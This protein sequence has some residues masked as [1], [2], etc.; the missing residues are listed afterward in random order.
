MGLCLALMP[1]GSAQAASMSA[2]D[3][4]PMGS[5]TVWTYLES[6]ERQTTVSVAQET[7]TLNNKK[8]T[9][10]RHAGGQL[11]DRQ[12]NYSNDGDG[13]LF[14]Y[15]S[16]VD[17]TGQTKTIHFTTP[18]QM[19]RATLVPGEAPLLTEGAATVRVEGGFG[20]V[21]TPDATF[22]ATSTLGTALETITVP[23]GTFETL[24]LE[25][26][27]A[28]QAFGESRT[29]TST[30][31]LARSM[32]VV[33]EISII[34]GTE[35]SAALSGVDFD[36]GSAPANLPPTVNTPLPDQTA[37][38]HQEFLFQMAQDAFKDPNWGNTLTYAATVVQGKATWP[39]W[40]VF[41]TIKLTFQGTPA[42]ADAGHLTLRVTARDQDGLTVM[43]EFVLDVLRVN[44]PPIL[45]QP[46]TDHTIPE[47]V[48]WRHTFPKATFSDPDPDKTL[49]FS[50]ALANDAPWPDWLTFHE[51]YRTFSGQPGAAHGGQS[52]EVRVTAQDGEGLSVSD[53]FV[54][55]VTNRNDPPV[56]QQALADQTAREDEAWSFEIPSGTF[57]DPDPADQQTLS[58]GQ[59]GNASLPTWL[60]FDATTRTLS[61]TPT[62]ADVGTVALT[63]TATD[64]SDRSVVA[65][66]TLTVHGT[67]DAPTVAALLPAQRALPDTSFAFQ[68]PVDTF[69]DENAGDTLS[70]RVTLAEGATWLAF[71]PTTRTLSGT[72]GSGDVGTTQ[73]TVTVTD[74]GGKIATTP[75][76]L[77]ISPSNQPP[78]GTDGTRTLLEDGHHLLA[79]TDFGFSDPDGTDTL[80]QVRLTTLP[81]AGTVTW[82]GTPVTAQQA[83]PVTAMTAGEIRYTPPP[84]A[85]G[86]GYAT[87]GFQVSDGLVFST[88][89]NTLTL[90][91]TPIN[92]APTLAGTPP[93]MAVAGEVFRFQPAVTDA[94]GDTLLF[95]L[96]HAPAW[97]TLPE[98]S[99][100]ILQGTPGITD[101]GTTTG[102]TLAAT[103][104]TAQATLTFDLTVIVATPTG[105]L[106]AQQDQTFQAQPVTVAAEDA[107]AL[108]FHMNHKPAWLTLDAD[109]GALSGT[110]GA[111]H[112]GT[113]PGLFLIASRDGKT[114]ALPPF[115]LTVS[116]LAP[117]SAPPASPGTG[118]RTLSG[119][120][121][122]L[123]PW[124]MAQ[125]TAWSPDTATALSVM[126]SGNEAAV[127]PFELPNL[128][129][130]ADYRLFVQSD[131][132]PDGFWD[133]TTTGVT[134]W[135]T[136]TPLNLVRQDIT[137]IVIALTVPHTLTVA[138]SGVSEGARVAVSAWS[139]SSGGFAWAQA[140]A[141]GDTLTLT[142]SG[143]HPA[144]DYRVWI[145][146]QNGTVRGGFYAGAD[147]QPG[148]LHKAEPVDLLTSDGSISTVLGAGRTLSGSV[149]SLPE[150]GEARIT[151]WSERLALGG[152]TTTRTSGFTLRGLPPAGDYR[153][154][155]EADG[156]AGGCYGGGVSPTSVPYA[157][158]AWVDLRE[159]DGAGIILPLVSGNTVTGTLT[160][161][162]E[163]DVAW[164]TVHATFGADSASTPVQA[165]GSFAFS[166]LR[167]DAE[168]RV[169]VSAPGY[170]TPRPQ[171]ISFAEVEETV[172]HF[173]LLAGGEIRGTL[174]GLA[175][176]EV[177]TVAV[178]SLT[179]DDH[180]AGTFVA[181]HPVGNESATVPLA[182]AVSGLKAASDHI[183][184][185]HTSRGRFF[186]QETQ[187]VPHGAAATQIVVAPGET[188]AG[189]D[190]HLETLTTYTL[191]GQVGGM[192]A[193]DEDLPVH[194]TA[195]SATGSFAATQRIGQ[196]PW[197]LSGLV[198]GAYFL[199]VHAEDYVD[200]F[201]AGWQGGL[202]R[203]SA[204]ASQ[205]V[206]LEMTDPLR[207]TGL[208]LS[209]TA[210]HRLT[211]QVVAQA[212]TP[213]AEV[214]V[215]LWDPVR[216]VGGG[217]VTRAD[218]RFDVPG[219]PDGLYHLE[220]HGPM[221][222][223][224]SR[225]DLASDW[226]V[227]ILTLLK[228]TG[229]M[230]GVV[231]GE[232]SGGVLVLVYDE[233]ERFVG[234]TVTNDVGF[235]RMED[236]TVGATYRVDVHDGDLSEARR[237]TTTVVVAGTMPVI[238]PIVL[239]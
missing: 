45:S 141:T 75:L 70:W 94:D 59:P 9:V 52:Y 144:N 96:T 117:P 62:Q 116:G 15:L 234:A 91:V 121:R 26:S 21:E 200:L 195:W 167:E 190:M 211:G 37:T 224:Q 207:R 206:A 145:E 50:A 180:Q 238:H 83:L 66:F 104:G 29:I 187:L 125:V 151:A 89:S 120:V 118:S 169:R 55:A 162:A 163:G 41:D 103:D 228:K 172:A 95:S 160:G 114:L 82:Q 48:A 56:V 5:G 203:W 208:D 78:T 194:L 222:G 20:W 168:Y 213:V 23:A 8:T 16:Y 126:L 31:W 84:N 192:A 73:V 157:Q 155:I 183:L 218:G 22:Q 99:Q 202:P 11:P 179:H 138:L 193:Q 65:P 173:I 134:S 184:S 57:T 199:A 142:L 215:S 98:S 67:N 219:L 177:V 189:R 53:T 136:A 112:V 171:T 13:L 236:L 69:V 139:E 225:L 42:D 170:Q 176:G 143:L 146:P 130:G 188:V 34:S 135:H 220:S 137:E 3:W 106:E 127:V 24:R 166:G 123:H 204:Q 107:A 205:A 140:T 175:P 209:L 158:A 154:C 68:I 77:V 182:Y 86:T 25:R 81:Q 92:D 7:T 156:L 129:A 133:Q 63:V 196:G 76:T 38:E 2:R 74:T 80:T 113:W 28:V 131:R 18:L 229:A 233:A 51:T 101:V 30:F 152:M 36:P 43:D 198:A 14:H 148:G 147:T 19:T 185:L 197:Q 109:T 239:P 58:A 90:N 33:Q 149:V 119:T 61:G 6:G 132:H 181:P 165:D 191:S 17:G 159:D 105:P 128:P 47:D 40:L 79:A 111:A 150:G 27:V 227:G 64:R 49:T 97:M 71:E 174:T 85:S 115:D 44:D 230:Q 212:G 237:G 201:F 32:G 46:L 102:I 110:P 232:G 1:F 214:Y 124:D 164:V 231:S 108:T 186:Y 153:V 87:L 35:T 178:R 235:Y 39:D 216:E 93:R 217:A 210:G 100:G 60:S 12:E 4:F 221:G 223:V 161:L 54:L 226:D 88:Q 122:G 10:M 72:P